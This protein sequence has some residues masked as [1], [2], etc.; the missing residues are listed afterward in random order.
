MS[1]NLGIS[2]LTS[3][4]ESHWDNLPSSYGLPKPKPVIEKKQSISRLLK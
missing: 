2:V 3:G 4:S 1:A